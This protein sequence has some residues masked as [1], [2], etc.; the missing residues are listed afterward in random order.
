MTDFFS[1]AAGLVQFGEL[2]AYLIITMIIVA[3]F[4]KN[5]AMAYG[6]AFVMIVIGVLFHVPLIGLDAIA[7]LIMTTA[8][9]IASQLFMRGESV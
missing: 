7:V 4:A 5:V 1:T 3:V 8:A 9:I 6:A 2:I